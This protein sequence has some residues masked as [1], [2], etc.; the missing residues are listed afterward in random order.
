MFF[1]AGWS[2]LL[3]L[4]LDGGGGGGG[5]GG[6]AAGAAGAAEF[7]SRVFGTGSDWTPRGFPVRGWFSGWLREVAKG[8][9]GNRKEDEGSKRDRSD[10]SNE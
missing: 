5:G 8:G 9:K 2:G 7:E 6:G 4:C 10:G 1:A 3:E